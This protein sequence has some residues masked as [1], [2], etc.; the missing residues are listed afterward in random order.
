[1]ASQVESASRAESPVAGVDAG[2]I[3]NDLVWVMATTA[4]PRDPTVDIDVCRSFAEL[5]Q[6]A[7][8]RGLSV[9]AVDMP[10][11]LPTISGQWRTCERKAR[12][13]LGGERNKA[14]FEAPPICVLN[15]N[16]HA[17]ANCLAT[18][19]GGVAL[20]SGTYRLVRRCRDMRQAVGPESC[21]ASARPRVAEVFAETCF[22]ELN[23]G[24]PTDF[25]KR[26]WR[27]D[28]ERLK[29]LRP[30]FPDIDAVIEDAPKRFGSKL[31]RFDLLD[32]VAAVWTALRLRSGFAQDLGEGEIDEAGYPMSIWI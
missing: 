8:T 32:A 20:S 14:V 13:L 7:I 16:D 17:E 31:Q 6:K 5:W 24:S 1:M 30:K 25:T 9:V 22:W 23:G 18:E 15:A 2:R 12:H 26:D 27:G 11:G 19:A 10:L 3:G 29:L 4:P 21:T 28:E